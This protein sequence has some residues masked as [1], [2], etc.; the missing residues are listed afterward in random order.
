LSKASGE[1]FMSM[2]QLPEFRGRFK[3]LEIMPLI[4]NALRRKLV[5]FTHSQ[6]VERE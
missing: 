3:L 4:A 2:G 1:V 5:R 6:T